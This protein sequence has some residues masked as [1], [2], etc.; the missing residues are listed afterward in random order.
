[1][2]TDFK[3]DVQLQ[4]QKSEALGEEHYRGLDWFHLSLEEEFVFAIDPARFPRMI[5]AWAAYEMFMGAGDGGFTCDPAALAQEKRRRADIIAL[6]ISI[7]GFQAFAKAYADLTYRE[8]H[9][10][11][12]KNEFWLVRTGISG[13][14]DEPEE[15]EP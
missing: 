1:M 7:N 10:M 9:A 8:A 14:T 13:Y 12:C 11:F 2:T 5:T 4:I 6:G 15:E 3:S